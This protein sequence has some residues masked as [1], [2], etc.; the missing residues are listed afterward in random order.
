[1]G[2]RVGHRVR[3]VHLDLERK[4]SATL[5]IRYEFRPQLARLGL[6]PPY[7]RDPLDRRE[8]AHGF[9]GPYCPDLF[10]PER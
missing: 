7:G 2:D 3:R 6:L 8:T 5:R 10:A 4:P 1:M 9:D